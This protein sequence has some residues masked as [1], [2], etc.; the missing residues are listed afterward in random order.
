MRTA[1]RALLLALAIGIAAPASRTSALEVYGNTGLANQGGTFL[2]DYNALAQGFTVGSTAWT[3]Q[4]VDIGFIFG[5][6]APTSGQV[7]VALYDNA[8]SNPGTQIGTFTNPTFVTGTA[9]Y[10]FAGF[11]GS[12]TLAANTQYW[13][14]VTAN[15]TGPSNYQ[16]TYSDPLASPAGLNG[17]GFTYLGTRGREMPLGNPT[18]I[19]LAAPEQNMRITIN[20][21]PEPSTYALGGVA[22]LVL[23]AAARRKTLKAAT[24]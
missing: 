14:V 18:W 17:S 9:L 19:S 7:T 4:S 16:W 11:T 23:G 2:S 3:L 12:T 8:S 10:N 21:V 20:A 5:A 24:A 13:V 22:A 6:I 1:V 15:A